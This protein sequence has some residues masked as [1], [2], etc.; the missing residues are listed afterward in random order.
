MALGVFGAAAL[1]VGFAYLFIKAS[2]NP[3]PQSD[4]AAEPV[5]VAAQNASPRARLKRPKT[6]PAVHEAPVWESA[7]TQAARPPARPATR[8]RPNASAAS[9][10][11][12]STAVAQQLLARFLQLDLNH[13][14]LTSQQA[15]ELNAVLRQLVE[16]G[17]AALPAIR[18][19]LEKNVD[20]D[21]DRITG[22]ELVN[23]PSLRIGL[24]D[25]LQQIGGPEAVQLAAQTLQS[26]A[27]PLE[28]ALLAQALEQM[29]PEQYRQQE[30]VAAREALALASSSQLGGRD[31]SALF[32]LLQRYGDP[33]V[34]PDLEKAV[35]LWNYYA[36]LALAGL[37]DGAGIPALIR[38]AQDPN[39]SA[40][41]AGDF[42]LRPLAQVA[43][44]YPEAA[45]ALVQLAR[46]NQIPQTAWPSV[47][48]SLAGVYIQYG[49][50]IFGS[51]ASSV[52]WSPQQIQQ[53]LALIDKLLAITSNPAGYQTLQSARAS[54]LNRLTH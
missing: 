22:G 15:S 29:A 5:S 45:D 9:P 13:K 34:V 44:Q 18:E 24:L 30:L 27:D 38:L 48:A 53:R 7:A 39:I 14:T 37:P 21:F 54:L 12:E 25:A 51:T 40:K 49:Q 46:S 3:T 42:A 47:A 19:F 26:T 32:E 43:L 52:N 35:A 6:T 10:R 23:Y 28:L 41:G 8:T 36:T 31:V 20:I 11:A 2:P 33:S 1:G 16:Q 50:Q 17:E 4:T